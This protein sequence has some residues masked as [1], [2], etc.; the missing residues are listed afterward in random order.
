M[1][2]MDTMSILEKKFELNLVVCRKKAQTWTDDDSLFVW[3]S[4]ESELLHA[5]H[6]AD[7]EMMGSKK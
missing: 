3:Y 2:T 7:R 1:D 4:Q 5:I 6:L